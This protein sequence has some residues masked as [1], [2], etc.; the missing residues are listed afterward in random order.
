MQMAMEVKIFL[1]KA[2]VL[3]SAVVSLTGNNFEWISR[4][5]P[6]DAFGSQAA[7]VSFLRWGLLFFP[8]DGFASFDVS[9][10]AGGSGS[11]PKPKKAPGK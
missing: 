9:F 5:F 1:F 2:S 3:D 4:C 10:L 11:G 6:S 8:E 7:D